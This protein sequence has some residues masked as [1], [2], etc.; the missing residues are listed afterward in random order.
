MSP[1][2]TG[3]PSM[4]LGATRT[5]D[6]GGS[7]PPEKCRYAPTS[8]ARCGSF[9]STHDLIAC[10]TRVDVTRARARGG[11]AGRRGRACQESAAAAAWR[12]RR[13]RR[14]NEGGAITFVGKYRFENV[15]MATPPGVST[16][17]IS[18]AISSGCVRYSTESEQITA[19]K[20]SSSYGSAGEA[21]RSA[22]RRSWREGLAASSASLRPMPTTRAKWPSSA[23]PP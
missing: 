20:L 5:S 8:H 7:N 4:R 21:L 2:V 16:R 10:V 13:R 17:A 15:K 9:I 14:E 3:G 23:R 18:L 12:C 6:S 22:T 19:S 1:R 11:V